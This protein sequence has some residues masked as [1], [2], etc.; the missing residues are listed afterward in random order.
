MKNVK[1]EDFKN[2]FI[3][4]SVEITPD[5]FIENHSTLDFLFDIQPLSNEDDLFIDSMFLNNSKIIHDNVL[6]NDVF[7]LKQITAQIKAIKKQ[8]VIVLGER[9]FKAKTIIQKLQNADTKFTD[10]LKCSFSSLSSAYN[11]LSYYEFFLSLPTNSLKE[12]LFSIPYKTAYTLSSKKVENERKHK[13]L[14]CLV[15]LSNG[16]ALKVIQETFSFTTED[17][18]LKKKKDEILKKLKSLHS[19]IKSNINCFS[20]KDKEALTVFLKKTLSLI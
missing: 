9:I 11:S 19:D 18:S 12:C 8:S 6:N 1:K 5:V 15:G 20:K 10:W 3:T 7:L 17:N 14:P 2:F 13:I 4:N 16:A